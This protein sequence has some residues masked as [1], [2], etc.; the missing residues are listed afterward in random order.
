MVQHL[1]QKGYTEEFNENSNDIMS[2]NNKFYVLN[3]D[4]YVDYSRIDTKFKDDTIP[5][6]GLI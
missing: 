5:T 1:L 6:T 4:I 2:H 3:E